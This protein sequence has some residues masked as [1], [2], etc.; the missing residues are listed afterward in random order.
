MDTWDQEFRVGALSAKGM[1]KR[2]L[3]EGNVL[4]LDHVGYRSVCFH[5]NGLDVVLNMSPF[6]YL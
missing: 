6:Y 5:Q 4:Y 1:K 3:G 2:L